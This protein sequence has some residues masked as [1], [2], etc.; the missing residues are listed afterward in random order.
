MVWKFI[1]GAST[2]GKHSWWLYGGNGELTAWAGEDFDS[3]SNALR[4]ARAFKAN[5]SSASF[6]VYEDT[7]GKWRWRAKHSS[8]KI[9]GSWEAFAS[10]SNAERAAATVKASAGTATGP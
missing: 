10:K 8:D 6:E 9:A 4:A 7:A 3:A 5:A 1:S 2:S